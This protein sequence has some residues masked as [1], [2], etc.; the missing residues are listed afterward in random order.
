MRT[1][2]SDQLRTRAMFSTEW[3]VIIVS[4]IN[5]LSG[6]FGPVTF[7]A[8]KTKKNLSGLQVPVESFMIK[9]DVFVKGIKL[10]ADSNSCLSSHNLL[11]FQC[12]QT[13][14]CGKRFPMCSLVHRHIFLQIF[15]PCSFQR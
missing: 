5:K 12:S 1:I 2:N 11:Q 13:P 3:N 15:N 8:L 7:A 14:A 9:N 6:N 10:A 4:L